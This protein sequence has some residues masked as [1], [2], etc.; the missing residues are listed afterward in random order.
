MFPFVLIALLYVV[1]YFT[2]VFPTV[3]YIIVV[4]RRKNKQYR[5]VLPFPTTLKIK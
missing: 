3:F 4:L 5:I 1:V 2:F